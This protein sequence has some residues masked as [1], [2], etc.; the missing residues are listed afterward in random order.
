M[1]AVSSHAQALANECGIVWFCYRELFLGR[2]MNFS[3]TITE[4]AQT[5]QHFGSA[6][7]CQ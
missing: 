2:N 5:L 6:Y 1:P 4:H 3:R 7:A